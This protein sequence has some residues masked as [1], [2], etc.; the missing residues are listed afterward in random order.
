MFLTEILLR[1]LNIFFR[2][3]FQLPL[4]ANKHVWLLLVLYVRSPIYSGVCHMFCAES[5]GE[6]TAKP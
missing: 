5:L 6:F 3:F 4:S 2:H 1:S